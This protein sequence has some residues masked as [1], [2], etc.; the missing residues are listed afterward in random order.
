MKIIFKNIEPEI[1]V[2]D[3]K[4]DSLGYSEFSSLLVRLI[5]TAQP[6]FTIAID[7]E[8]GSGKSSIL[9]FVKNKLREENVCEII[10]FDAWLYKNEIPL[11]LPLLSSIKD[12]APPDKE[13]EIKSTVIGFYEAFKT[14]GEQTVKNVIG[15]DFG[16][17]QLRAEKRKSLNNRWEDYERY[18]NKLKK[19]KIDFETLINKLTT[20]DKNKI[21]I[22][23]DN[24]DRCLPDNIV[25]FLED[26]S[27]FFKS[28]SVVF[29]LAMDRKIIKAAFSSRYGDEVSFS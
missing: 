8:W 9:N 18:I 6:P 26:I 19:W 4:D 29:V 23:V 21:V 27:I 2:D 1:E 14:V 20:A 25:G 28:K 10:D 3:Q 11:A 17:V 16:E 22:F 5:K 24:I 7:G 12:I 15:V 13:N